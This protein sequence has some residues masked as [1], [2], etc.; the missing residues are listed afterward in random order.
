MIA[1]VTAT[2]AA[3]LDSDLEPLR[4][5]FVDRNVPVEVADWDDASVDW[6]RFDAVV[7]RSTW[8]YVDRFDEFIAWL[9]RI[10]SLTRVVNGRRAIDWNIDKHYLA[11]LAAV[12]VPIVPTTFVELGDTAN[13][14]DAE[15]AVWVVKPAIGAG[16]SGA[17]RC[18]RAEVD[19]HIVELHALGRTAMVQPYLDM[20][21]VESETSLVFFNDGAGLRYD[22]AFSKA[23]ILTAVE[24]EPNGRLIVEE[25]IGQRKATDEQIGLAERVL[26]SSPVRAVGPLAYARVDVVPTSAG[27]VLMELE[28]IEPSLYFSASDGSADRAASAWQRFLASTGVVPSVEPGA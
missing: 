10:E 20:I 24:G 6:A 17:K 1:L 21:D 13:G 19:S 3:G 12:D 4:R 15:R 27:P 7:L 11:E 14:L 9:D 25:E 28:L 2:A 22:H 8:D 16:S 26:A 23:A 5:A 18:T